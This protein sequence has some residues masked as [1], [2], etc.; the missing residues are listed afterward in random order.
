MGSS[1]DAKSFISYRNAKVLASIFVLISLT[2]TFL[3][4]ENLAVRTDFGDV[5]VTVAS[6]FGAAGMVYA[7]LSAGKQEK[8]VRIALIL[9]VSGLLFDVLAEVVWTT[10]EIVL[11]QQPFPSLADG[12]YLIYYPLFALG[13]MFL[14][15]DRL[16][17]RERNK[18][19]IDIV[20]IM[21]AAV[22]IFWDFIIEPILANGG[23]SLLALT[24]SL[25]Y[26]ALDIVLLFALL[27]L[28]YRRWNSLH[29]GPMLFLLAAIVASIASDI[30]FSMQSS[31]ETYVSG[32]LVDLGYVLSYSFF[33]LAGVSQAEKWRLPLTRTSIRTRYDQSAWTRYLPYF[34]LSAAYLL[35]IW[36]Q[37]HLLPFDL[38][39]T[40]W[41]V[42]GI[43]GLVLVRQIMALNE[44][45]SLYIEAKIEN[46]ERK[47]AEEALR[48]SEDKY[49]AIFE[50]TG[51]AMVIIEEDTTISLA[52]EEFEKLTGYTKKQAEGKKS[53]TEFV[54]KDDLERMISQHRIRRQNPDAALKTY[55]FRLMTKNGQIK[56]ILLTVDVISGTGK[57]VA[58]LMDISER[59]SA[60]ERLT[61]LLR[62]HNEMLDTAAIWIDMF[63]AEG[64]TA[65]WNLAAERISGYSREEVLGHAKIWEWLYPDQEY[66]AKMI[67]DVTKIL[68]RNERLENYETVIR[69][70]NGEER[71]IRWHSNNFVNKE[72]KIVGGIGIGDDITERKRSSE[73]LK[74]SEQRLS[75]IIDFLPDA[76]FVI[77]RDGKVIS[78]NRAIEAMTGVEAK[79]ILGKGDYEYAVPFYGIRKP[80]LIDLVLKSEEGIER[81]YVNVERK[82]GILAGEAYMP[83]LKG[84]ETYLFGTATAL[85]D[86]RGN[87]VGAIESIRDITER[88]HAE[89]ALLKAHDELERRVKERTAELESRNAEME[90]FVYTVSHELRSPLISVGGVLGFLKKDLEIGDAEVVGNDLKLIGSA[91]TRM[92]KLLG[93]TLELSRV[94]RVANPTENV[95]FGEI[96]SEALAQAAERIRS[97]NVEISV[98]EDWPVVYADR[99]RLVEVLVNLIE[100]SVKYM[101][102]QPRPRIEIGYKLDGSLPVFFVRD[103]GIGIDPSQ[104]DKVFELFYKVGGT[105]EGTGA[106][107][108]I[109]KRIIEVLGGRIWI[110]SELGKGCTI[111]FTLPLA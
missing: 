104:H 75:D 67:D 70:K 82:G 17:D 51:T 1:I 29:M 96:V 66:R 106:G 81:S 45:N 102:N 61:S 42:G 24:L 95:P 11:H 35:L 26:P 88:R 76:T 53:W 36:N 41:G 48:V 18:I 3:F 5:S 89:E 32:G 71:I 10:F 30:Y 22:L 27:E 37:A 38:S 56:D 86:S 13:I 40:T 15:A 83:N 105:T 60:E 4:K 44:N 99:M 28:L 84:G 23:E 33:G 21:M 50:N 87:I 63:D 100:N 64:C 73:A 59:K 31:A 16:S 94:G 57:S 7:L 110:E 77:D 74:D 90:R 72:G 2:I 39:I 85:C 97:N 101:G 47:A 62:F 108:A 107:L 78:W 54:V 80:V 8:N 109:V 103:N 46:E 65:F 49:R 98:G 111:C 93:E 19:I 92:D 91:V 43:I 20:I 9:M 68:L 12:F 14:P 25:A 69:R 58:S 55:E 52:N 79:D 6:C 34:G